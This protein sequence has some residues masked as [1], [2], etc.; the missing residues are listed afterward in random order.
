MQLTAS[1]LAMTVGA[2]LVGDGE[3]TLDGCAALDVAGPTEVSFL[4]NPKYASALTATKAGAVI[5][6]KN[7]ADQA[8]P[9]LTLLI[10][11]SP[12]FAFRQAVVALHGFRRHPGPGIS[13]LAVVDPGAAL[14]E[15]CS[16]QPFAVIAAGVR[17]GA[18]SVIYPHCYI[19]P[20]TDIGEDCVIFSNVTVYDGCIL[21]NRVTI[22]AGCVIGQDG[23]GYATH[24]LP[25][26]ELA[27]HKIPQVGDVVIE[28][29]VEIGANCAIDRATIGTTRIGAGT[30]MSDLVTIGHG[31]TIGRHNLLVAQVGIAGS[32]VTGDYVA[33]G[34]QAG[35]AGHLK[36]G[37]G[38]QIAAQSGVMTDIEPG[39]R[40]GGQPALPLAQAKRRFLML[41]R[42]PALGG[43]VRAL[44][45]RVEELESQTLQKNE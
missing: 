29:D 23:F 9:G 38:A 20:D 33:M 3:R 35:I 10:A 28:D 5:L 7:H 34:G 14:G 16:V 36:I 2:A 15:G 19:G 21:G 25:G 42:L 8:P 44:R 41:S 27:H 30:K 17:I 37:P 31:S 6:S 40:Y 13:P 45:K 24:Q 43:E 4:A 39:A 11:P 22:H 18:R 32:T 12:Y 26:E 1:Q